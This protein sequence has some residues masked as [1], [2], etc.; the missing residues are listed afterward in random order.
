MKDEQD[1]YAKYFPND[2]KDFTAAGV[3]N[4]LLEMKNTA[5]NE[6]VEKCAESVKIRQ[7]LN[8]KIK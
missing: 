8:L 5:W 1:I 3:L 4:A 7:I 6:A 2:E